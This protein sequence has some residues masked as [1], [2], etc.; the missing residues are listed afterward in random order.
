M[1]KPFVKR[2]HLQIFQVNVGKVN[3]L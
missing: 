2:R 3:S 1:V